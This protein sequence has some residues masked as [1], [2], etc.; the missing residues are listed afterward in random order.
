MKTSL[1]PLLSLASLGLAVGLHAQGFT[2]YN[3]LAASL[4]NTGANAANVTT[5]GAGSDT[6]SSGGFGLLLNYAN[7]ASTGVTL[8]VGKTTKP[9]GTLYPYEDASGTAFTGGDAFAIFNGIVDTRGTVNFNGNGAHPSSLILTFSGLSQAFTYE[10]VVAGNRG[11]GTPRDT[12]FT[13]SG[14]DA[15]T[16]TSSA[17]LSVSSSSL[18][19][20]I[21]N[22]DNG[23]NGYVAR[24]TGIDA[25][26]DGVF[27]VTISNGG[28]PQD[29]WYANAL[30]LVATPVPEPSA[31]AALA[32]LGALGAAALRRRRR[33]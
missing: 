13:L 2:A 8:T 4:T 33:G 7:G 22:G 9:G 10:I 1:V 27:T 17:A 11:N 19:T 29:G 31:F 21:R 24:W 3:D 5:F 28:G 12:L 32:G 14:A 26:A 25:G 23:A 6:S 16:N 20:T 30:M 15:W 18:T